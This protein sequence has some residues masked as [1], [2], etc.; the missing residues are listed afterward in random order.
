MRTVLIILYCLN[1]LQ[2]LKAQSYDIGQSANFINQIF[3]K[4]LSDTSKINLF[5]VEDFYNS[6]FPTESSKN[7]IVKKL[8]KYSTIDEIDSFCEYSFKISNSTKWEFKS[9]PFRVISDKV[10]NE[11]I[12]KSN[13]QITKGKKKKCN[14]LTQEINIVIKT[15]IP[16][17]IKEDLCL[18]LFSKTS[19]NLSGSIC[20]N[21][22]RKEMDGNW[23]LQEAI[24]YSIS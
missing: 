4:E 19:G 6:I 21:L 22:Y 11:M 15:S 5:L 23:Y 20:L 14:K 12:E 1:Y 7:E 9:T 17:F 24:F 16:L 18:I 2:P 13:I 10:A 3:K 8:I